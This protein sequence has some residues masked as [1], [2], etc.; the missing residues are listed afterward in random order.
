MVNDHKQLIEKYKMLLIEKKTY[1]QQ[2]EQVPDLEEKIES[3]S[4]KLRHGIEILKKAMIQNVVYLDFN[5]DLCDLINNF[6]ID[7]W[8][9]ERNSEQQAYRYQGMQEV[10]KHVLKIQAAHNIIDKEIKQD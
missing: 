3:Q 5:K 6:T 1:Q 2:L 4:S 9:S 8:N 10:L 7:I